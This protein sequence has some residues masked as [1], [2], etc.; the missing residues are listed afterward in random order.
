M[1]IL[2]YSYGA[3]FPY[4]SSGAEK[5]ADELLSALS[6]ISEVI[7]LVTNEKYLLYNKKFD[8]VIDENPEIY[9]RHAYTCVTYHSLEI[10]KEKLGYWIDLFSPDYIIAQLCDL[11]NVF[12]F[13]E[14][15]PCT[16]ILY[17]FHGDP[18]REPN[19]LNI[20]RN[21]IERVHSI[22]CVSTSVKKMLDTI[23]GDLCFTLPP[24]F[25]QYTT[26]K[27]LGTQDGRNEIV[28]FNTSKSKGYDI[29]CGLAK[30]FT[31][32]EFVIYK[33]YFNSYDK[34]TDKFV[35]IKD[36]TYEYSLMFN[37]A[38][39]YLAPSQRMEGF[40]RGIIE[41]GFFGV[42]SLVSNVSGLNETI[43]IPKLVVDDYS[44]I[45]SWVKK[46]Q[47]ILDHEEYSIYSNMAHE[48]SINAINYAN[49]QLLKFKSLLFK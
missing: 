18:Y 10:L 24:L 12:R 32:K 4:E 45:N 33:C 44:D 6:N 38:L 2:Y 28:M 8:K 48:N 41:A 9:N 5:T 16:K 31:D 26:H 15:K 21:N 35:S 27:K 42:P 43:H 19:N 25:F 46:I 7:A 34:I 29:F 11:T 1:K 40:G 23:L 20:L 14:H 49:L 17:Y 13:I 3:L 37:N 47:M 36:Y 30:I 39:L 22:L